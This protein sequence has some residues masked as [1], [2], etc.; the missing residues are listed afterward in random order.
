MRLLV[1]A[2]AL[3]VAFTARAV[4]QRLPGTVIPEHYDLA[5]TV[6]LPNERF[7]GSETIRVRVD[8]PTSRIV[9]NAADLHFN[10][11]TQSPRAA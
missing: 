4:A 11:V 9:L 6:D 5:F 2:T 10:E 8:E 7:N 3:L 1:L